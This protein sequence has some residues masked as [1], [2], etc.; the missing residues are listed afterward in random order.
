[1][2]TVGYK[3]ERHRG[4]IR[5]ATKK[6]RKSERA[7]GLQR[8]VWKHDVRVQKGKRGI[9]ECSQPASTANM[10]EGSELRSKKPFDHRRKSHLE[11]RAHTQHAKNTTE[12]TA[13][14][15]NAA[16]ALPRW[17]AAPLVLPPEGVALVCANKINKRVSS[18][19]RRMMTWD[20]QQQRRWRWP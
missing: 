4:R 7:R 3:H 19:P 6:Q 16:W 15:K 17:C 18:R 1:M 10:A 2:Y 9:K 13:L 20:V 8:G 14:N 11:T 5:G 12:T